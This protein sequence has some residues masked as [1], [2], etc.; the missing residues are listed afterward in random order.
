MIRLQPIII[1]NVEKIL[2]QKKML[3][4]ELAYKMGTDESSLSRF[5]NPEA[6]LTLKTI[7]RLED[8]LEQNLIQPVTP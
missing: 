2:E 1:L 5:L 8:A 4:K 7:Q 3:R 6:N